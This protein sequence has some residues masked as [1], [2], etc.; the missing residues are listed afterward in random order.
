M[1]ATA[2]SVRPTWGLPPIPGTVHGAGRKGGTVTPDGFQAFASRETLGR[3]ELPQDLL[4]GS[5]TGLPVHHEVCFI[6]PSHDS[7]MWTW[8]LW[9][10]VREPR[11]AILRQPSSW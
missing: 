2:V 5:V 8:S 3:H 11:S 9:L 7:E 1:P 4:R 10:A 6:A